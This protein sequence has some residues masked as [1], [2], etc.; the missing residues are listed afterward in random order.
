MLHITSVSLRDHFT[1]HSVNKTCYVGKATKQMGTAEEGGVVSYR[2]FI[3]SQIVNYSSHDGA[4]NSS[5]CKADTE[6][7]YSCF[8]R[9][10]T[11]AWRSDPKCC[12]TKI[13]RLNWTLL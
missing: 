8:L 7:L 9:H 1:L 4:G 10:Q 2:I 6:V 3:N 12:T 13:F 11:T 5:G